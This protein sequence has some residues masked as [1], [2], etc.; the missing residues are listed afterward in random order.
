MARLVC[1]GITSLDG[2]VADTRGNFGW[3]R[4]DD[5][6]LWKATDKVVWC[7]TL[8]AVSTTA[9]VSSARLTSTRSGR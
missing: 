8:D 7:T 6:V 1:T 9:P 2:D 4:P 5:A 3:S